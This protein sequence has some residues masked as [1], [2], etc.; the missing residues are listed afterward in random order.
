MVCQRCPNLFT[1]P[2]GRQ[3][4]G[5]GKAPATVAPNTFSPE[6]T[7]ESAYMFCRPFGT[8]LLYRSFTGVKTPACIPSSLRDFGW[9]KDSVIQGRCP[10]LCSVVPSGLW[11]VEGFRDTGAMPLPVFRRPFGTLAAPT[12]MRRD[13]ASPPAPVRGGFGGGVLTAF[14]PPLSYSR[15]SLFRCHIPGLHP[16]AVIFPANTPPS[17]PPLTGAGERRS[18]SDKCV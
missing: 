3:S 1:V 4:T 13:T 10:C 8:F 15:P 16:A 12:I 6:G 17:T 5:R 9:W 7:A 14:T 2:K 18:Y 11:V